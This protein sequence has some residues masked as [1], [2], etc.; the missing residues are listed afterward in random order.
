M[1]RFALSLFAIALALGGCTSSPASP[2]GPVAFTQSDLRL[3]SGAEAV[4]GM[5]LTVQY[6]G[7][8]YDPTKPDKRGLQFDTSVGRGPFQFRLGAGQVIQGW[9]E[10]L[11]GMKVEGIRQLIIPPSLAYGSFRNGPIPANAALVFEIELVDATSG[12]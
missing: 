7:W 2:T 1:R 4:A 12:S 8:L 9:D 3:G 11:P 6:T 10:G 5:T